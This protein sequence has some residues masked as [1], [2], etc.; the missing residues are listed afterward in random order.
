MNENKRKKTDSIGWNRTT[1][2]SD[3]FPEPL[4]SVIE[5]AVD[6]RATDVHIDPVLSGERVRFRVDGML[7]RKDIIESENQGRII[8]QIKAAAGLHTNRTFVP[9]ESDIDLSN[10]SG[11]Y[12]VRV[13]IIPIGLREAAH[14]RF[15]A[16]ERSALKIENLGLQA[17]NM[18][19]MKEVLH[20]GH[21]LILVAGAT[22]T[23]KT[24]TLYALANAL[25]LQ[26]NVVVSVEDP[27]EFRFSGMRQLEIDEQHGLDMREGLRVLLRMDPDVILIGEIRD[28]NSATTAVR[29]ALA[30]R[31]VIATIHSTDASMAIDALKHYSV[32]R[33]MLSGSLRLVIYQKLLRR[34][35][36]KCALSRDLNA[37]EREMYQQY[38]I[39]PPDKVVQ[40]TGCRECGHYGYAGRVGIFEV[41]PVGDMLAEEISRGASRHVF[42]KMAASDNRRTIEADALRKAAEGVVSIDDVINFCRQRVFPEN[43]GN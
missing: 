12:N 28:Q 5:A 18:R 27:V 14:L 42:R 1:R 13:S 4:R 34:V 23:G 8:N 24:T 43:N 7:H 20:R 35:C 9:L 39:K 41:T 11:S 2:I 36:R 6:E 29:A 15:L 32:S 16:A 31:L 10:E 21:G 19:L 40:A 22:G 33:Y 37:G 3:S 17:G 38:S 25:D 30:G 26:R